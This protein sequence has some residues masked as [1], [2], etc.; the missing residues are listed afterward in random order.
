MLEN[1]I[2]TYLHIRL[3][4]V[5]AIFDFV[6]CGIM[7]HFRAWHTADLNSAPQNTYKMD[8]CHKLTRFAF[9][10]NNI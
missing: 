7:V 9:K 5:E 2:R 3:Q 4:N 10:V 1:E 6:F 8:V